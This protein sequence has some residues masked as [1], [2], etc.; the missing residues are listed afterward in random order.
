MY[1]RYVLFL[2]IQWVEVIVGQRSSQQRP[3]RFVVSHVR[4]SRHQY[5]CICNAKLVLCVVCAVCVFW[6]WFG[7]SIECPNDR[8]DIRYG[9]DVWNEVNL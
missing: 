3:N 4:Q 5:I 9:D 1:V 2:F 8:R 6:A 7:E